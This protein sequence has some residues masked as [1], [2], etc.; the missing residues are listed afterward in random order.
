[1]VRAGLVG[2]AI[3]LLPQSPDVAVN[4]LVFTFIL[5]GISLFSSEPEETIGELNEEINQTLCEF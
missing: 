1:M 5:A 4:V 2:V 3:W